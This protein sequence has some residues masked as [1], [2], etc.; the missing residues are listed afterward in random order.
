[1]ERVTGD[2]E[3]GADIF[4]AKEGIGG[5]PAAQLE[6][7]LTGVVHVGFGHEDDEFVAAITRD[8]V[9]PAAIG[10]QDVADTLE[11]EVA[12]EVAVEIV[13]KLEAVQVHEDKSEGAAGTR[14]ALPFGGERFHKKTVR[15]DAGQAVGDGLFLG[16]L[17]RK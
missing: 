2:A 13:D 10:F 5:D 14:G 12:F 8:D 11:N 15:L 17:E 1:M 4:L 6:G 7:Q 9:G 3:A 16:F